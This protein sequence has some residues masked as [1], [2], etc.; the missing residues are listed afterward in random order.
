MKSYRVLFLLSA[1]LFALSVPAFSYQSS[2]ADKI[3]RL[4]IVANSDSDADQALKL[5]VRDGVLAAVDMRNGCYSKDK[6]DEDFLGIIENAAEDI[7]KSSGFDYGVTAK[8][9]NM[10]FDTRVYD[11]FALPCGNYDAVR[12]EIGKAQGKNWWCVLF[13]P[14]CM[15]LAGES[16]EEIAAGAGLSEDDIGLITRDGEVFALRFKTVE[17]FGKIKGWMEN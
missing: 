11:G 6:I 13:P 4:H 15:P 7:I 8:L 2:L 9:T 17:L 5:K 1:L 10:Y 16:V 12:V 3:V 14:L